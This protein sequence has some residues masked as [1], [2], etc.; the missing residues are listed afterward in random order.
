MPSLHDFVVI[1]TDPFT[2]KAGEQRD[3]N[4]ELTAAQTGFY[5]G[6]IHLRSE[7]ATIPATLKVVIAVCVDSDGDTYDNCGL[8]GW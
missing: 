6:T 7:T 3:F 5:D 1:N 4:L 8:P 2:I